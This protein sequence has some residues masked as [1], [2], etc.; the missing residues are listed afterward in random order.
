M[1]GDGNPLVLLP[2]A[3]MLAACVNIRYVVTY[4]DVSDESIIKIGKKMLLVS[5]ESWLICGLKNLIGAINT[6]NIHKSKR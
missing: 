4:H 5:S 6:N 2:S 3:S 1:K